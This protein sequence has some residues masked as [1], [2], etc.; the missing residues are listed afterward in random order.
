M[1]P[2]IR[3][4]LIAKKKLT[5]LGVK[6]MFNITSIVL[7]WFSQENEKQLIVLIYN[8]S[9]LMCNSKTCFALKDKP[10]IRS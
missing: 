4:F 9:D 1:L 10:V 6:I 2:L 8:K 3:A 7:Q 5:L